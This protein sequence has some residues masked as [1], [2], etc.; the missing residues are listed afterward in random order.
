M[1]ISGNAT[2]LF[3]WSSALVTCNDQ[4]LKDKQFNE[5]DLT[6][7]FSCLIAKNTVMNVSL[8]V[9][10]PCS[11]WSEPQMLLS[12]HAAQRVE[13]TVKK[14]CIEGKQWDYSCCSLLTQNMLCFYKQARKS[15]S[16]TCRITSCQSDKTFTQKVRENVTDFLGKMRKTAC[17]T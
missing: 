11:T 12:D 16:I 14:E 13:S 9:L 2:R 5:F 3:I 15:F 4:I 7:W 8:N 17:G 6:C 1:K 10:S